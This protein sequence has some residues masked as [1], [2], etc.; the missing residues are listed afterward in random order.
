VFQNRVLRK[1][2]GLKRVEVTGHWRRLHNEEQYSLQS[3]PYTMRVIISRI[4]SWAGHVAG[5]GKGKVHIGFGWKNL[6]ER[7]HMEVLG[8]E[9]M[10]ILKWTFKK[11]GGETC[12]G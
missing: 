7:H 4:M 2:F 9:E 5:M 1:M 6:R 10:I 8:V 11:R 12:S 3:F